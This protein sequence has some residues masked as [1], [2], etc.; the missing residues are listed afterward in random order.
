M[1][2]LNVFRQADAPHSD[3][4]FRSFSSGFRHVRRV[5]P[6]ICSTLLLFRLSGHEAY[7]LRRGLRSDCWTLLNRMQAQGTMYASSSALNSSYEPNVRPPWNSSLRCPNTC[8]VTALSRQLPLRPI[9]WQMPRHSSLPRYP[10]C[11]YCHPM[12]E[13]GIGVAPAGR[14]SASIAISCFCCPRLGLRLM[15]GDD[16]LAAH[17]VRRCFAR[18]S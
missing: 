10:P 7:L 17:V 14:R 8:L 5:I 13:C 15:S 1:F 4:V 6:A 18:V 2:G 16:L 3:S 11:W 12:S 9:D